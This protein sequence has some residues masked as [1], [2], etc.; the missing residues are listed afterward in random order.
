MLLALDG[1]VDDES[2]LAPLGVDEDFVEVSSGGSD[3]MRGTVRSFGIEGERFGSDDVVVFWSDHAFG[4]HSLE[5]V[6]A[7]S[8]C[9]LEVAQGGK[10]MGGANDAGE[11]SALVAIEFGGAD[12]EVGERGFFETVAAGAE[13]DAI[14]VV[15]EDFVSRIICFDAPR[16]GYLQKLAMEARVPKVVGVSHQLHGEG[17]GTLGEGTIADVSQSGTGNAAIVDAVVFKKAGIFSSLERL[18]EEFRD[19]DVGDESAVL[20]MDGAEFASFC[21]QY[22][23][24]LGHG[25]NL[26]EIVSEGE[27]EVEE[28]GGERDETQDERETPSVAKWVVEP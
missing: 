6:I 27:A 24:A 4:D 26:G 1:G 21:I 2:T 25:G 18:D 20:S 3:G 9:S 22:N 23:S 11:E 13:V 10:G 12:A 7:L 19:G 28:K 5:N 15:S 8:F 16:E 17:G 14:E